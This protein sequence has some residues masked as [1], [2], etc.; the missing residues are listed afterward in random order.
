M[1]KGIIILTLATVLIVAACSKK[2]NNPVTPT[3]EEAPQLN[4]QNITV[5]D[6]MQQSSDMHAQTVVVYMQM[7]NI[8]VS[9]MAGYI[10]PP[11]D[12]GPATRQG[13]V[14]EYNWTLDALKVIV[15]I[16]D[17]SDQFSWVTQFQGSD[18]NYTYQN[19][20]AYRATQ[21]KDAKS[22]SFTVYAPNTT[23]VI[24]EYTWNLDDAGAL[25]FNLV[26]TALQQGNAYAGVLNADKSGTLEISQAADGQNVLLEKYQW[27]ADG[28]GQWWT[29]ENGE[30]KESGSWQ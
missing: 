20:I 26:T 29:Y 24:G 10:N 5:P 2:D 1:K 28:S 17:D 9:S 4:L 16:T 22:G 11:S 8:F 7:A 12:L 27:N 3:T 30:I 21:S 13:N 25:H 14:W 15:R 6:A 19:W 23:L 18:A